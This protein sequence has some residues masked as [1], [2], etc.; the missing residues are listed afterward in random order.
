MWVRA[1]AASSK[2][3]VSSVLAWFRADSEANLI[4]QGEIV[5]GRPCGSVAQWSECSHG[6][7]EVLGSSPGRAMCIFLPCDIWWLSVGPCSG[8][9]QQRDCLVGP[10][11]VP[12]R[13]GDD[14]NYAGGNCHRST[15]GSVA[16]WSECSHGLRGVLGSSPGRA[17]CFFL[18]CD[19]R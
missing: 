12:S 2:G 14:S 15:C 11:M 16:Q 4:K 10:G 6:M 5:T 19:T 3:T 7:R 9:E 1:R 18:P 13:F 8:C 17:M